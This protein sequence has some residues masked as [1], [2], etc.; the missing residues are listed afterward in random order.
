MSAG[1]PD[2][3]K[4]LARDFYLQNSDLSSDEWLQMLSGSCF[5]FFLLAHLWKYRPRW[6][7]R[8]CVETHFAHARLHVSLGACR[9]KRANSSSPCALSMGPLSGTVWPRQ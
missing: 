2:E 1:E 6:R 3:T 8:L 5:W 4:R 7:I 9:T